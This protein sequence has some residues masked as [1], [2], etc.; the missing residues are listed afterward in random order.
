[1]NTVCL[2]NEPAREEVSMDRVARREQADSRAR[3]EEVGWTTKQV[4]AACLWSALFGAGV[5]LCLAASSG[6]PGNVSMRPMLLILLPHDSVAS[7]KDSGVYKAPC[8]DKGPC[9]CS[10]SLQNRAGCKK[11]L[12]KGQALGSLKGSN[13]C[14]R[15]CGLRI[16]R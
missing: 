16:V 7:W 3:Q 5:W 14:P 8:K 11:I 13:V 10:L 2:V 4:M 9:P 6:W 15:R 12:E 1:M